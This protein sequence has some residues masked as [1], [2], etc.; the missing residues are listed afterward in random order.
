VLAF[1]KSTLNILPI[2]TPVGVGLK[3][4]LELP[5]YNLFLNKISLGKY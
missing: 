2:K 5:G 3:H 4:G 1:K